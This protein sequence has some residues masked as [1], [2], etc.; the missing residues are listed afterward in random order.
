MVAIAPCITISN[1]ITLRQKGGAEAE[2]FIHYTLLVITA[3]KILLEENSGLGRMVTPKKH[4]R[5]RQP[6]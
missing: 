4:H 3:R 5:Q 2:L 1:N 6:V